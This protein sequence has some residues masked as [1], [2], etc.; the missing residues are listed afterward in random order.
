M[1]EETKA[2][3]PTSVEEPFA[4]RRTTQTRNPI[5][6]AIL[7]LELIVVGQLF[8]CEEVSANVAQRR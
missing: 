1:K 4:V 5:R 6:R 2:P 3:G 8:V 7:A